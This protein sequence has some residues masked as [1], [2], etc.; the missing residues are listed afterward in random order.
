MQILDT[1]KT[2]F[3]D[4]FTE[5]LMHFWNSWTQNSIFLLFSLKSTEKTTIFCYFFTPMR[6]TCCAFTQIYCN[7]LTANTFRIFF[8]SK[9]RSI[10][11]IDWFRFRN[12]QLIL[13]QIARKIDF[14]DKFVWFFGV[15]LFFLRRKLRTIRQTTKKIWFKFFFKPKKIFFIFWLRNRW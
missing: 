10:M 13:L 12:S 3:F 8:Y 7:S 4:K 1:L 11:L 6:K 5:T 9:S 14:S 2:F 15:F